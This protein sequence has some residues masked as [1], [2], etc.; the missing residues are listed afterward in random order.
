MAS[1]RW[2]ENTARCKGHRKIPFLYKF[3]SSQCLY[4]VLKKTLSGKAKSATV[5]TDIEQNSNLPLSGLSSNKLRYV[6]RKEKPH[7]YNM[8]CFELLIMG[9]LQNLYTVLCNRNKR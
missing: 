9:S 7:I 8:T 5:A 6:F 2:F 1:A 3:K 4:S